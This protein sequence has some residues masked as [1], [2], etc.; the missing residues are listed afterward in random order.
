MIRVLVMFSLAFGM[1]VLGQEITD[2]KSGVTYLSDR[3]SMEF[4]VRTT[5]KNDTQQDLSFSG[6]ADLTIQGTKSPYFDASNLRS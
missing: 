6:F 1:S 2:W 4:W 3:C 5:M